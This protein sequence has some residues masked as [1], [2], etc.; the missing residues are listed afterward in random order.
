MADQFAGSPDGHAAGVD[1]LPQADQDIA[2]GDGFEAFVRAQQ[3]SLTA[4]L[5]RRMPEADVPD[6]VQ[7]AMIRLLRYRALPEAQLRPLMYRIA[8]NVMHDRGRR[9]LSHRRQD[10]VAL[11]EHGAGLASAEPTQEEL[12]AHRQ[13]LDLV[14][15]AIRALPPRCREVYL[16]NRQAGMSYPQIARHCD[17]SVKAVE[18]HIS[19][20]LQALRQC[21]AGTVTGGAP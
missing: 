10:H 17:I 8:Q 19:R 4:Y 3:A 21:L 2:V 16:L 6:V 7:E 1:G 20:A 9:D 14:R 5:A 15:N 13:Q 12:V 18:K 11:D